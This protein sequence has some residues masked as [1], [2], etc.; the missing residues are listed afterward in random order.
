M[1]A[2]GTLCIFVRC[3]HTHTY[4]QVR[5]KAMRNIGLAFVRMGQ[6]QDA[7]QAFAQVMENAPEHQVCVCVCICACGRV[8]AL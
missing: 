7:L 5:F 4:A 2:Q 3:A 8:I 6:Y 1:H